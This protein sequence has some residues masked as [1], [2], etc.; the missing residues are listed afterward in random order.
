MSKVIPFGYSV[1]GAQQQL[2]DLMQ[3]ESAILVDIRYSTASKRK[4]EWSLKRLQERYPDRYIWIQSLGNV[5]FYN[6]G[7]PIKLANPI[8]GIHRLLSGLRQGYTLILLC[9]CPEYSQCHRK[10]VVDALLEKL[11]GVEVIQPD[12]IA[13]PDCIKCL[14]V[15]QPYADWLVN[16]DRFLQGGIIP[17]TIENREWSTSYRGPL[18]IH[19][20]TKF[21]VD[22]FEY[23]QSCCPS[24]GNAVLRDVASP[25][26][27]DYRLGSLIGIADLVDVVSE[28]D[29]PWFVGTY[30][31][32]LAHAR[33]IAPIPYRGQLRLFN[34]P[35]SIVGEVRVVMP[36]EAV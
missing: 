24:L 5:N 21:E 12:V 28:S 3:D 34:V 4:P 20:S 18:L 10:V 7:A 35:L 14:S 29:D 31:F 2:D 36:K 17:K 32:V 13:Q 19:A 16:P 26:K 27:Q 9:T 22:A 23:W 1:P 8:V 11:P 15:R 33:P 6:H 30:G 25:C